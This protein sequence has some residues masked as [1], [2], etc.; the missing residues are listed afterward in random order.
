MAKFRMNQKVHILSDR[1]V[2]GS[3]SVGVIVGV[4]K[5]SNNMFHITFKDYLR[6]LTNFEYF[7][8]VDYGSRIE[9]RRIT[10]ENLDTL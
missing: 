1:K 3:K 7:V 4:V 2:D 10:E 6:N 9:T 5:Y 8:A